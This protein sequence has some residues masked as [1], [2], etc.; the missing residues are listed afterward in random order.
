MNPNA[1]CVIMAGGIGNRFWPVSNQDCPKQFSDILHTGKSFIRQTFER[2]IQIFDYDHIYIITGAEYEDITRQQ[3]PE[4]A[5]SHILKEP[6]R[7]NTATCIMYAAIRLRKKNPEATMVV[8]PSDHFITN[9]SAY[10]HDLY[11]GISF[12]ATH[13]GLLTIGITPSRAE[14]EY[15]YIQI[16]KQ[17]PEGKIAAVKTFTEK[18]DSELAQKFFESGDFLWNAGIFIWKVKDIIKE[19]RLHLYDLYALFENDLCIG[20]PQEQEFIN[21]IYGECPNV[22]IDFGI[23]EKSSCVYVLKG[24]FGWSDVGTWHAFQALCTKDENHNVSCQAQVIFYNSR[25]C[26]VHVPA[27]KKVIVQGAEDL[28][29]A[30]SN[31]YLMVCHNKDENQIK[32]F[33]KQFKYYNKKSDL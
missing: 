10:L 14:T 28:I 33:E 7:R 3:I 4:I 22:S 18:P 17:N 20:T 6:F 12:A 21:T 25:N 27:H 5:V 29:I 19:F 26:I 31:D 15:G 1:Y 32:H 30:E 8:I 2:V 16:K 9:D 23:L 24:E 11:E 13:N